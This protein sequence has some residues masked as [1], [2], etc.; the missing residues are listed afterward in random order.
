VNLYKSGDIGTQGAND[1]YVAEGIYLV[2]CTSGT[3]Q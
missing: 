3:C 2:D 1:Y